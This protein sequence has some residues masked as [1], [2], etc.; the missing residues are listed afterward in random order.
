M[1]I[2]LISQCEKKALKETRRIIDQ[3]AERYGDRTWQTAITKQG[4]ETLYKLLKKQPEKIQ[5]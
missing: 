2:L 4:L 3:F 5:R 1:N